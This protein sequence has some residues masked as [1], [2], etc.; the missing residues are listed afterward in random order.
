MTEHAFPGNARE[1]IIDATDDTTDEK[2]REVTF[3]YQ[4]KKHG[5]IDQQSFMWRVK[6][7]IKQGPKL[8]TE[9]KHE[10]MPQ[11]A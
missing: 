7:I 10:I 5:I 1:L 2:L 11:D 9:D 3:L 6:D 8:S 4:L